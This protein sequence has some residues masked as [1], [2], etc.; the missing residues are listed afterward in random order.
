[1]NQN[2][3]DL[4]RVLGLAGQVRAKNGKMIKPGDRVRLTGKILRIH[5]SGFVQIMVEGP[6]EQ[7]SALAHGENLEKIEPGKDPGPS[8]AGDSGGGQKPAEG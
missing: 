2:D 8:G 5:S 1:M 6:A 3:S 4:M 7:P